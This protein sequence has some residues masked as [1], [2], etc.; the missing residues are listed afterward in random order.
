MATADKTRWD[1]K[2]ADLPDG[3][4]SPPDECLVQTVAHLAPGRALDLACGLGH[5]AIW[6]AGLGWQV[7]AVDISP[8]GLLLAEQFAR[9]AHCSS[10]HWIAA[11][12]ETYEAVTDT[13]DLVLVFRFLDRLRLPSLVTSALRPGGLL[14]Y[15]TFSCRQLA[16]SDNHL[17]NAAF[18]LQPGELQAMFSRLEVVT[19]RDVDLSDRSVSQFV[20]R[21]PRFG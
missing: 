2:Y 15:E 9:E 18:T 14:V 17:K 4:L 5:N 3:P 16:R 19:E 12:L 11:D 1:A 6:L 21:K 8:K 7:D 13:Y 10:I 20:A